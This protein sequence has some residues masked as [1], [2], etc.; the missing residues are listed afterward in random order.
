LLL[1][2]EKLWKSHRKQDLKVRWETGELLNRRLG[3]P[4]ERLPNGQQVLKKAAKQVRIAE[5]DL[6]RMRWFVAGK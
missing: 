1:D 3:P 2:L 6:S 5:S 4:T